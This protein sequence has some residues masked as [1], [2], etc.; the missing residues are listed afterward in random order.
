M[1]SSI[2]AAIQVVDCVS[3]IARPRTMDQIRNQVLGYDRFTMILFTGFGAIAL[4]L[5]TIF[6]ANAI[7]RNCGENGCGR[8]SRSRY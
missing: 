8:K 2:A 3:T 1:T 4:L 7:S 5:V 6:R